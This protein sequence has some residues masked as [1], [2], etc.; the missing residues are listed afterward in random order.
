M[1]YLHKHETSPF[2]SLGRRWPPT[3]KLPPTILYFVQNNWIL[4]PSEDFYTR[5]VVPVQYCNETV[6]PFTYAHTFHF[7]D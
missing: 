1:D 6:Y 4:R 7:D 5:L 3:D 2:S